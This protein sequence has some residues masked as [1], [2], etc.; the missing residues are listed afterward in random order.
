MPEPACACTRIKKKVPK[1]FIFK[2]GIKGIDQRT[3]QKKLPVLQANSHTWQAVDG[4]ESLRR[5]LR[6]N[7]LR[8]VLERGRYDITTPYRNGVLETSNKFRAFKVA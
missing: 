1:L 3:R 7:Q 4:S 5:L 6:K 2:I 8:C